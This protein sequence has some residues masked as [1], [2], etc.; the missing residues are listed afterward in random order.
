MATGSSLTQN[1]SRSQSE[2]QGDLHNCDMM[3]IKLRASTYTVEPRLSESI[4]TGHRSDNRK[5]NAIHVVNETGHYMNIENYL[6][7]ETCLKK[8]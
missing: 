3:R 8:K 4:G 6:M 2:I 5:P 1:Y 7:R